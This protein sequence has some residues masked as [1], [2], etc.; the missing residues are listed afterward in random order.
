MPRMPKPEP[1]PVPN[2]LVASAARSGLRGMHNLSRPSRADGWQND[3]HRFYRVIPEFRF[4]CDWVGSMLSKAIIHATQETKDGIVK[5]TEGPAAEFIDELFD[6]ADG[7]AEMFRL[8]GIH[9]TIAGEAHIIAYP[10]TDPYGDGG[11]VWEVCGATKVQ[12]PATESGY[13]RINGEELKVPANE[14]LHIRIWRPDPNDPQVAIAP[15][16]SLLSVLGELERLTDHVA[17][18]VD[19][20]LAGAGILLMPT[21]MTFPVP[22]SADGNAADAPVRTANS[23]EDLVK[24]ISDTMGTAIEDRGDPSALV[25]IVI[26]APAEAID[27]VKHMTFWTELDEAAIKMRDEAIRRLALGMDMPPEVL[28]GASESN[29]WSAWQADESAIK[30][31]TEPLLKIITTQ[32]AKRYLRPLLHGVNGK[33]GGAELRHFSIAADT[34]EMRLRPNRSKEA[35]ELY[36]LGILNRDA[37]VRETG[38]DVTDVM[39]EDEYA[40]WMTQKVAGGSTTPDLV[41]AAL[42]KIG[43]ELPAAL[44]ATIE[45][46]REVQEARPTPSLEEHPTVEIPDRDR[47]ERRKQ[48]REEGNVPSS[49]VERKYAQG[50]LIAAADQIVLRALERAGNRLKTKMSVKPSVAAATIYQFVNVEDPDDALQDAW[51]NVP[52]LARRH[53]VDKDWLSTALHTYTSEILASHIPHDFQRFA[54]YM[55]MSMHVNGQMEEAA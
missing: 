46:E 9:L 47:S 22:P 24:V 43:V 33:L 53:K 37:V 39:S 11:D 10:D 17:A 18:Q 52:D 23:A 51:G 6:N 55:V 26:T 27:K 34:S 13:W 41:A 2:S 30:S 14:V 21:E 25:P 1:V 32:L 16:L 45:P 7:K 5:V 48:A 12:R 35:L 28:Q 3:A 20:R 8:L 19:S 31:H 44:E 40:K 36:N 49:D 50:A 42:K 15:S 29:H 54:G 38:F 4:G